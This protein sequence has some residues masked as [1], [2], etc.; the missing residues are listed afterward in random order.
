MISVERIEDEG[1]GQPLVKYRLT[2]DCY[3]ASQQTKGASSTLTNVAAISWLCRPTSVAS[4][5]RSEQRYNAVCNR[6]A[7]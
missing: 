6:V 5:V 2:S 3:G 4:Q 7:L 1:D